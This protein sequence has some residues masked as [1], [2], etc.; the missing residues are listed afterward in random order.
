MVAQAA[1]ALT[2]LGVK[3]GDRVAV[4]MP[5][6]PEAIV[7]M[8]AIVRLGAVHSVIFAGFSAESLSSRILDSDCQVVVT[9]DGAFRRGAR[10][11]AQARGRRGA[12]ELS[13]RARRPRRSPHRRRRGVEGRA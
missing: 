3:A 9:A 7:T 2:E 8:L 11:S 5:M 4:Y 1:N 12:G 10:E 13:E 6:I